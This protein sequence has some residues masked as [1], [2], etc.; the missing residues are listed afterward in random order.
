MKLRP[1]QIDE[2][3]IHMPFVAIAACPLCG[4]EVNFAGPLRYPR[5]GN[6]QAVYALCPNDGCKN[7]VSGMVEHVAIEVT[8]TPAPGSGITRIEHDEDEI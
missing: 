5:I 1:F 2:K 8:V 7:S 3:R 6:P 4:A